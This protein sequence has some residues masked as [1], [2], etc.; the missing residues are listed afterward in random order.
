MT[1]PD[2]V[3][4]DVADG[5]AD[6]RLNR[7]D[8]LNAL[9]DALFAGLLETIAGLRARPDVR[10]VVISGSGRAFCAGLDL[11]A[12]R[13]MADGR[14]FRPADADSGAAALDLGE[15]PAELTRGQRLV[16]G[17]RGLPVPVI[18]AVRGAA[19][20]GGLQIALGAHVRIV[21]PDVRLGLLE[22]GWGTVPDM[23]GTQLLPRL[24]GTD[25]ATEMVLSARTVGAEEAVRIGLATRVA[26]DPLAEAHAL[27]ATIAARNPDAVRAALRLLHTDSLLDGLRAE[28]AAMRAIAGSP[29][30]REAAAARLAERPPTF[31]PPG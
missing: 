13:A 10:A 4:C 2:R 1:E 6:V 9:D 29:N 16:L 18:A 27:A 22:M 7:P 25:V 5:V 12:F 11:T 26:D 15:L 28:A 17:L 14:A 3:L 23:G 19:L 20:G 8:K 30:Q 31:T 21:A 24:V